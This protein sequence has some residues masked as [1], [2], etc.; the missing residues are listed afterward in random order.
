VIVVNVTR[1]ATLATRCR[2]A[3]GFLSRGIGLLGRSR[4]A[5]G[6]GLR[7]TRTFAITML[8]MRFAI[9]AVFLDR[10]GRVVRVAPRLR[11][12][13]PM[14]AAPGAVEVIELPAGTAERTRTQAGDVLRFAAA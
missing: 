5:D 3:D 13:T 14:V 10:S 6:E 1:G 12:W 4:L 9:D 11:P 8:F 7:I 2:V